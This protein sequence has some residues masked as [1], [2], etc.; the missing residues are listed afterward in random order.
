MKQTQWRNKHGSMFAAASVK[1]P[2]N[3]PNSLRPFYGLSNCVSLQ[4]MCRSK[5]SFS[6][7]SSS[8]AQC[9]RKTKGLRMAAGCYGLFLWTRRLRSGIGIKKQAS[10]LL[11]HTDATTPHLWAR[12]ESSTVAGFGTVL[13]VLVRPS[14]SSAPL[15][16]RIECTCEG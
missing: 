3:I 15:P 10:C 13:V 1:G 12:N 11:M 14:G 5:S 2:C 6:S 7:F 16:C 8:T 4:V 9:A